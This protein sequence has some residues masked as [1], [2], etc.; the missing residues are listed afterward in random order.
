MKV[1]IHISDSAWGNSAVITKWHIER[2]WDITGYHYVILNGWLSPK[3]FNKYFDGH[4]ETGRPL[5]DDNI[6]EK[7]EFG[8]H[9]RGKNFESVSICL[10]GKDGNFTEKQLKELEQ[11]LIGLRQQ[12]ES[13]EISQHSDWDKRKPQCAGLSKEY[14]K[15]LN[16]NYG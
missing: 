7:F 9:T 8:A 14:I 13:L 2:G 6:L 5:D 3:A 1:I 12:F 11:R 15:E 4:C 10:I 16:I